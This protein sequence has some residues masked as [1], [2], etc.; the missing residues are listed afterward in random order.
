MHKFIVLVTCLICAS[1]NAF[2]AARTL[3]PEESQIE[4]TVKEMGVPVV[5]NFK[6][7]EAEIDFDPVK[8]E[9]SHADIRIDIGS[10]TTG[11][12][13]ADA[14]AV[15]TE[16]LDKAHAPYATF[17]SVSI[18]ALGD[19]NYEAHGTLDI[20]NRKRDIVVRFNSADQGDGK[21]VING[22][23]IVKRSEFGI[24]GGVWNEEG[25]V[26]EDISVKVRIMLA[27]TAIKASR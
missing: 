17:K 19:G 25:V 6:Q 21:T 1:V 2:A 20:R 16:W 14:I 15:A 7:F 5:G 9:K 8:P 10:L 3:L 18:L 12:E 11:N 23:F 27:Q 24:G 26:A 22:D 13:E 4:F